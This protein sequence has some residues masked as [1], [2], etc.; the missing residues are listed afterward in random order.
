MPTYPLRKESERRSL[1]KAE[2]LKD[3]DRTGAREQ[4]DS[5]RMNE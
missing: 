4:V 1:A 3:L 2:L 5:I